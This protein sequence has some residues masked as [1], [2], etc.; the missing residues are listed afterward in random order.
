MV[1]IYKDTEL[2]ITKKNKKELSYIF[3]TGTVNT[4]NFG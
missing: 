1:L 2:E 3:K 4:R